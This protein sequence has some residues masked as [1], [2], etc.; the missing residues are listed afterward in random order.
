LVI[1]VIYKGADGVSDLI[2]IAHAVARAG[3]SMDAV[4]RAGSHESSQGRKLR[5]GQVGRKLKDGQGRGRC[6]GADRLYADV[7]LDAGHEQLQ[8]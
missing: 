2:D 1:V 7:V 6:A 8:V 4:R 3:R 5:A